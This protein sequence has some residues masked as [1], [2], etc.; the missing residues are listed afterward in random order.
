M[1]AEGTQDVPP[2]HPLPPPLATP[3][4]PRELSAGGA[5][6]I[7]AYTLL[8]ASADLDIAIYS[9]RDL[10]AWILEDRQQRLSITKADVFPV[11][12]GLWKHLRHESVTP[13]T[14]R[15][16]FRLEGSKVTCKTV[17]QMIV[18]DGEARN[19]AWRLH[20][21]DSAVTP[22]QFSRS[23]LREREYDAT[24]ED[25]E[26]PSAFVSASQPDDVDAHESAAPAGAEEGFS[27]FVLLF[28][29]TAEARRFVR[30]WHRRELKDP[31]TKRAMVANTTG[32]W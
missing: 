3:S 19:L 14:A 22:L 5:D 13:N 21:R 11:P 20:A 7:A 8:P 25:S 17:R 29:D 9:A 24:D 6:V 30:V 27:Q 32:L 2:T 16:L 28:N 1:A 15:V 23:E 26:S 12:E 31:R 18:D 10:H 4:Q